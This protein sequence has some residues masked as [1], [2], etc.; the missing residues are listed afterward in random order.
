MKLWIDEPNHN[1]KLITLQNL[2]NQ[3][4]IMS[5]LMITQSRN[6]LTI[7]NLWNCL[8]ILPWQ[9]D[10]KIPHWQN[11][12]KIPNWNCLWYLIKQKLLACR[13]DVDKNLMSFIIKALL[14]HQMF[15][16]L[17]NSIVLDQGV[18]HLN[19]FWPQLMKPKSISSNLTLVRRGLIASISFVEHFCYFAFESFASS[20]L[21]NMMKGNVIKNGVTKWLFREQAK[22]KGFRKR[23]R[24][25][26]AH[27]I[28]GT[29]II[30][31]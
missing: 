24:E 6:V 17:T 23:K 15:Q 16:Y 1:H 28:G 9:N 31:R 7:E 18:I 30:G 3:L 27:H 13:M 14:I 5:H 22:E 19:I 11:Y 2:W 26:D 29:I 21:G 8:M 4:A 10:L 20:L 25:K 12:M